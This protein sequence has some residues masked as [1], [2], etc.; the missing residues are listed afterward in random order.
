[1]SDAFAEDLRRELSREAHVPLSDVR[2]VR[3]PYRFCPLGAHVDHQDGIVT[4]FALDRALYLA[5]VPD[6]A[7]Q[8]R[9]RSKDAEGVV[10]FPL[11]HVP[12]MVPGDWGNYP[13]GAVRAL[14]KRHPLKRGIRGLVA[15]Q[16]SPGGVSTSGG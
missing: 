6:D 8:V 10:E 4:G 5:F 2:V 14:A 1:M 11:S 3:S 16:M 9:L 15:G 12:D 7:G 13:R